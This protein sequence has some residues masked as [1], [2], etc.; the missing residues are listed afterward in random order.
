ML[1]NFLK[2]EIKV[3]VNTPVQSIK[4]EEGYADLDTVLDV[5]IGL[6]FEEIYSCEVLGL[7]EVPY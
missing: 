3:S 5:A 1:F 2:I 4:L 6:N 7:I